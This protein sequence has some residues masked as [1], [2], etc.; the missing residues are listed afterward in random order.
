VTVTVRNP[1][2]GVSQVLITDSKG[3]YQAMYLNPGLYTITA[4]LQGFKK[5]A[6]ANQLVRV[7]DV[8]KVDITLEA[9][10]VTEVVE[11]TAETP[12]LSIGSAAS[13]TTV[14]A[15]QIAQ[16]PL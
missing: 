11:V 7:G 15:K 12:L 9:G 14:D 6:L 5:V 3:I 16:L 13:G 1:D 4:Q 10:G 2:T 8:T